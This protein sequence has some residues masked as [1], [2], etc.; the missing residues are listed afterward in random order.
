MTALRG[1]GVSVFLHLSHGLRTSH[2]S[3]I[4][5]T[6]PKKQLRLID[7]LFYNL[8]DGF[9]LTLIL[10]HGELRI[11]SS[12]AMNWRDMHLLS[13]IQLFTAISGKKS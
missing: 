4:Y 2:C 6:L 8:Q 10:E 11:K 3:V 5:Y 1:A 12:V 13:L 9:T 7:A